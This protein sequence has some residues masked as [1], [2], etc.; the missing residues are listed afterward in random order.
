M[1]NNEIEI[2]IHNNYKTLNELGSLLEDTSKN[3][4]AKTLD[5]G[6]IP[7]NLDEKVNDNQTLEKN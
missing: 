5:L 4:T 1:L 7:F 3:T 2:Y 6:D